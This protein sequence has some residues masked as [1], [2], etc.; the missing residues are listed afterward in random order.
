M[1]PLWPDRGPDIGTPDVQLFL[2]R[3]DNVGR[4]PSPSVRYGAGKLLPAKYGQCVQCQC[5]I[6][7]PGSLL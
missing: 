5:V 2:R 6:Q 7:F 3:L 1:C 4:W